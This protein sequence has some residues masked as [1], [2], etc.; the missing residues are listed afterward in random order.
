V[1][2]RLTL[3]AREGCH[4]CDEMVTA[5]GH[6]RGKLRFELEVVDVDGDPDLLARFHDKVPVLLAG[7]D[8]I[9]R[10]WLNVDALERYLTDA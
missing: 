8:E 6:L 5:L 1:T 4:L 9:C 7:D 10:Y 2:R 3:V